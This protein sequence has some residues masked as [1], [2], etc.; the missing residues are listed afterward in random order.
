MLAPV[1]TR[2][3]AAIFVAALLAPLA[4]ASS[5]AATARAQLSVRF[6]QKA[7]TSQRLAVSGRLQKVRAA[8]AQARL[9]RLSGRR[10]RILARTPVKRAWK[11]TLSFLRPKLQT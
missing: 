8:G 11:V 6:P 1:H 10:W 2:F 7:Y 4:H 3:L 9:E 5:P